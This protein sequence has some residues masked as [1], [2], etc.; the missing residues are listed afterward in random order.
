VTAVIDDHDALLHLARLVAHG[1]APEDVFVAV[2]EQAARALGA[3]VAA[4]GRYDPDDMVTLVAV[5]GTSEGPAT[6]SRVPIAMSGNAVGVRATERPVRTDRY[7]ADYNEV[8]Y[9]SGLRAAVSVPITVGGQLWGLMTVASK[10]ELGRFPEGTE[11]RL[12]TF[13]ELAVLAIANAQARQD[14][15]AVADEQ[16]ALRRIATLVARGTGPAVVA[17][18]VAEELLEL[19][20]ADIA[21]VLRDDSDGDLTVV[22]ATGRAAPAIA[23]GHR[24]TTAPNHIGGRVRRTGRPAR[25]DRF[26]G[27]PGSVAE[28]LGAAGMALAVA[29]PI[30]VERAIWGVIT[31]ASRTREALAGDIEAQLAAFGDLVSIAVANARGQAEVMASRARVM[32]SG[33]EARLR[34]GRDL[35]DGAQQ[36]LVALALDLRRVQEL[37]P[38][39]NTELAAQVDHVVARL[40]DVVQELH[41]FV[42]GIHPP[43]LDRGGLEPALRALARRSPVPV[44]LSVAVDGPLPRQVATNAYFIAAEAL[45]NAAKHAGADAVQVEVRAAGG[46][47]RLTVSDDGVGGADPSAG[48]GLLGLRDRVAAAMGVLSINSPP[49]GGTLLEV[50][51]PFPGGD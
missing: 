23:V 4:I 15:A 7:T 2:A 21:W 9:R 47:L 1:A 51:L 25:T 31:V 42:R 20:N 29:G 38:S 49:G 33:D 43:A 19:L 13:T 40:A 24:M 50:A 22:G 45:T 30:H 18:A 41:D 3:E 34:I 27:P 14:L 17:P 10:S 37:I 48:S 8:G 11:E 26:D 28:H 39:E 32:A 35:H 44:A 6:G 5:R 12:T 46:T 16:A 36:R